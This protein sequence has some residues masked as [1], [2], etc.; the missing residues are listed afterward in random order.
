VASSLP[1]LV[2]KVPAA[3][4]EAAEYIERVMVLLAIISL[5]LC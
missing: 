1:W 4:E 2:A 3:A 5:L